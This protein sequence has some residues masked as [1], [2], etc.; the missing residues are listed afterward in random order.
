MQKPPEGGEFTADVL[1]YANYYAYGSLQPKRYY[2]GSPG[3]ESSRGFQ[4]QERDDEIYGNGNAYTAE[5]WEY[6]SRLGRRWNV[7]PVVY[8]FQ[9]P[10]A[11]FNNNPIYFNDPTGL[12]GE[13]GGSKRPKKPKGPKK[14]DTRTTEQWEDSD[15]QNWVKEETYVGKKKGWVT[16]YLGVRHE[17]P[18]VEITAKR[19]RNYSS[20]KGVS[21]ITISEIKE[22]WNNFKSWWNNSERYFNATVEVTYG[23]QAGVDIK[24]LGAKVAVFGNAG[25]YTPFKASAEQRGSDENHWDVDLDY[26]LD[27]NEVT[28]SEGF[29]VGAIG[30]YA[31]K[32]EYQSTWKGA[33]KGDITKIVKSKTINI[34]VLNATREVHKS[35][36]A[37]KKEVTKHK[38]NITLGLKVAA[39][40]GLEVSVE[41]GVKDK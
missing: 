20:R 30:G 36:P 1:S 14:G 5:Y 29:S 22:K 26:I 7:D 6:D 23:M 18:E 2:P 34:A 37:S 11:T 25:S 9:S 12:E 24:A 31:Y 13:G 32:K 8:A 21:G 4:G 15:G 39:L 41:A 19:G 27:D 28:V 16:S 35:T 40:I 17:L 10:Y 38:G 3:D 33:N